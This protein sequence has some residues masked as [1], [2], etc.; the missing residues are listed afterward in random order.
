MSVSCVRVFSQSPSVSLSLG[1]SVCRAT[2]GDTFWHL[3]PHTHTQHTQEQSTAAVLFFFFYPFSFPCLGPRLSRR[4]SHAVHAVISTADILTSFVLVF[5][6]P[7]SAA[8]KRRA[9]S[10][11]YGSNRR[12]DDSFSR[13]RS[14]IQ[15]RAQDPRAAAWVCG[16]VGMGL[17]VPIHLSIHRCGHRC[18]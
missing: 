17:G 5:C 15:T 9:H 7:P 10:G 2:A 6:V 3:P 11:G 12:T 1:L 14:K 16:R 18:G 4:L 8:R 13:P